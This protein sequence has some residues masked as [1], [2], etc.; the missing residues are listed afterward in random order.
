VI[1]A[2]SS[3]TLHAV[4]AHYDH[5]A[6]QRTQ[7]YGNLWYEPAD[8]PQKPQFAD[9]QMATRR[10][11]RPSDIIRSPRKSAVKFKQR[12]AVMVHGRGDAWKR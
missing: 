10:N 5:L 9:F 1:F 8:L 11:L 12:A 4:R 6:G 2:P 3:G 7:F